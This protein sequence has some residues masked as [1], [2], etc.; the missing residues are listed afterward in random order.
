MFNRGEKKNRIFQWLCNTAGQTLSKYNSVAHVEIIV[1]WHLS[2]LARLSSFLKRK[3]LKASC[4]LGT[5]LK[6]TEFILTF[7]NT[8][9][10]WLVLKKYKYIMISVTKENSKNNYYLFTYANKLQCYLFKWQHISNLQFKFRC[11]RM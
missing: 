9:T 5:I 7:N 4:K 10:W 2:S 1:I 8:M 3:V 11:I 6:W